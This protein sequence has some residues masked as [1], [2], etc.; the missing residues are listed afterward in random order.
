[1]NKPVLVVM[2]AGM[3][4]RYGG[5][6]Q[7]DP[8]DD[9]GHVILDYS[10]FDAMRA[11]FETVVFVI[12]PEIEDAVKMDAFAEDH[13]TFLRAEGCAV[14]VNRDGTVSF[15]GTWDVDGDIEAY[16][17][18]DYLKMMKKHYVNFKNNNSIP[19]K[20]AKYNVVVLKVKAPAVCLDDT[21]N[22]TVIVGRDTE[23]YGVEVANNIKCDG[24]EE[25]WIFDFTDEKEFSADIIN[26]LNI[27]WAYSMG[28]E[29]NLRAEFVIMGFQLF[30]TLENALAATGGEKA[31]EAPTEEKTEAPTDPATEAPA[32][33]VTEPTTEAPVESGCGSVMGFGAA[34]VLVAAAAVVALKKKD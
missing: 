14:R 17:K 13:L 34:A 29:S 11:G 19:N 31:T 28:E 30:D 20:S 27:N 22:M 32:P 23:I 12:K 15:V 4:S 25:Y 5:L 33:T 7:L 10:V 26:S 16:A 9:N 21:P 6:K 24:S 3:G 18:I 1:M 2:A 8:I